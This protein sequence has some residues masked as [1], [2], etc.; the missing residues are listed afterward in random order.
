MRRL[1]R[2]VPILLLVALFGLCA[3]P[4]AVHG[5]NRSRQTQ[6]MADM[7]SIATAWEARAADIDSYSVATRD[8][9]RVTAADL[10]RALEPKYITKLPRTDAW[11]TDFQFTVTDN[12]YTI[13]SLGSDRRRDRIANASGPTTNPD[14]D[15]IF[16]NGSFIRYPEASG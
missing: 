10:A 3:V 8:G 5:R 15:I 1:L 4:A 11:G 2:L 13:R 12:D 6:T 16:S 7:Q 9:T 14:D